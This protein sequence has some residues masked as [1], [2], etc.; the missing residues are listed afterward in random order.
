MMNLDEGKKWPDDFLY[1][2]SR[3]R[4]GAR[5]SPRWSARSPTRRDHAPRDSGE[6]ERRTFIQLINPPLSKNSTCRGDML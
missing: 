5:D 2:A 3:V 6:P 1:S 4:S